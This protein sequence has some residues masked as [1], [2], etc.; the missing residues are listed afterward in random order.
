MTQRFCL[1]L[2]KL[3]LLL[4]FIIRTLNASVNLNSGRLLS[5]IIY[6]SHP[7]NPLN[8]SDRL[9]A[10]SNI[11]FA[12][13]PGLNGYEYFPNIGFGFKVSKNLAL[14]GGIFN[15]S[16]D[17]SFDQIISGGVQYFFGGTDTLSWVSSVKKSSYSSIKN[18]NVNSITFDISKWINFKNKFF[19]FGFGSSFYKK[20]DFSNNLVGQINF[21]FMN[22]S[23]PVRV[24]QLGFGL[25]INQHS[26]LTSMFIQ[27]DFH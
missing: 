7:I 4:G 22:I 3:L 5:Q 8:N 13:I 2:L 14:E 9:F 26:S 20:N 18:Y 24:F 21:G 16:L 17:N 15:K 11:S 12:S 27:K 1:K 10:L 19:R 6:K 25:E 23:I